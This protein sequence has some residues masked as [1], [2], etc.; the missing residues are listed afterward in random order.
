[1]QAKD[2]MTTNVVTVDPE[3]DVAT[4]ARIL[5]DRRIS[6][7]PVVDRDG[8]V[9]GIVSEGDLMRRSE[10][11]RGR[12]WWLSLVADTTAKFIH[13]HGTRA[14]DVMT[15]DIVSVE[16]EASLS[17][18]ARLLESNN[19][20]R[21]PVIKEGRLIGIV[22]RADILRGIAAFDRSQ[23]TQPTAEDRDIRAKIIKLVKQETDASI[24]QSVNVIV[25]KGKVYLWG[26]VE[27]D[28]DRDALRVAAENVVGVSKVHN[29]LNT[30]SE[31]IRGIF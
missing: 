24:M 12:S 30:F 16:E 31:V 25:V 1:M 15:H 9:M 8:R 14:K 18:V 4:V 6:A 5:L 13:T 3:S 10:C 17:E 21:V 22:S 2:V 20:K 27:T 29:F 26:T 28:Q 23:G 11:A 19:V 7:V